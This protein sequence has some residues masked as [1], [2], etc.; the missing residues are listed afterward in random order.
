MAR[1]DEVR[2]ECPSCGLG[3][4]LEAKVCQF[5][6]WD[7][8]EEDE[9]ILEIEKLEQELILEKQRFKGTSVEKLIKSTLRSPELTEKREPLEGRRKKIP[10]PPIEFIET[11]V[12][13]SESTETAQI[14]PVKLEEYELPPPPDDLE[15]VPEVAEGPKIVKPKR[16]ARVAPTAASKAGKVRRVVTRTPSK[17]KAPPTRKVGATPAGRAPRARP[18]A[19]APIHEKKVFLGEFKKAFSIPESKPSPTRAPRPAAKARAGVPGARKPPVAAE[20]GKVK[21]R[22]TRSVKSVPPRAEVAKPPPKSEVK[23]STKRVFICPLCK[24]GVSEDARTCDNCGAE[25]E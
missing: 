21:R 8:E 1:P 15:L 25:F 2:K 3:V 13:S 20:A 12:V 7:F 17:K 5:C 14:P 6:G 9:W 10:E 11:E 16:E 24:N 23:P 22:I 19:P 4:P 18:V